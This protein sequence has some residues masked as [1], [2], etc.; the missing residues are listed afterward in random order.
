VDGNMFDVPFTLLVVVG[1]DE[2]SFL[3]FNAV[4]AFVC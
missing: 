2:G 3:I 4:A 1:F